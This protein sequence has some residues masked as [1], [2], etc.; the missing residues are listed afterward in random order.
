MDNAIIGLARL[1]PPFR[2]KQNL[3][4]LITFLLNKGKW[5]SVFD[6]HFEGNNNYFSLVLATFIFYYYTY[7]FK[8]T[9][10]YTYDVYLN[11]K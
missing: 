2:G 7:I 3:P 5:I 11:Q 10:T 8:E 4:S 9:P 6:G 1:E